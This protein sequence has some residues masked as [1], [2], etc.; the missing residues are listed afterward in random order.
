MPAAAAS[1]AVDDD[2]GGALLQPA[3]GLPNTAEACRSVS[4]PAVK[5]H[6]LLI[7][8]GILFSLFVRAGLEGVV[9]WMTGTMVAG[10]SYHYVPGRLCCV[11][12]VIWRQPRGLDM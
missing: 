7:D 4:R 3:D 1:D 9:L 12:P 6:I 2:D 5:P 10:D 8:K 11:S